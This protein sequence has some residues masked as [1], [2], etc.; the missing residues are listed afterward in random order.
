VATICMVGLYKV[1]IQII[2]LAIWILERE[3]QTYPGLLYVTCLFGLRKRA[4]RWGMLCAVMRPGTYSTHLLAPEYSI[5]ALLLIT[6]MS[7]LFPL[8]FL[9]NSAV[10]VEISIQTRMWTGQSLTTITTTQPKPRDKRPKQS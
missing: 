6:N 4:D 7:L 10:F 3:V 8:L 5:N 1:F 9:F 2:A